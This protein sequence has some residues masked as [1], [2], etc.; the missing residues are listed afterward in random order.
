M[1]NLS[2]AIYGHAVTDA[3]SSGFMSSIG[4]RLYDT[5]AQP[6]AE[7]PYCVYMII[8]DVNEWEFVERFEDVLIQFSIYSTASGSTEIKDIYTKLKTLY[9][10]SVFS[11]D[12]N[13]LLWMWRNNLTTM[14]DSITTPNGTAGLWH[15][16]VDYNLLMEKD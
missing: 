12:D 16:A 6:G 4:S 1:K 5:E 8:S 11:I 14:R 10:E 15:Y 3:V 9:D 7:Y 13:T 2:K